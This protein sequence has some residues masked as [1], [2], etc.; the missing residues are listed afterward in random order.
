[1]QS[2]SKSYNI[3]KGRYNMDQYP[4]MWIDIILRK[5]KFHLRYKSMVLKLAT[6]GG[7]PQ[8]RPNMEPRDIQRNNPPVR[9]L[10]TPRN[11]LVVRLVHIPRGEERRGNIPRVMTLKILRKRNHS[12][13]MEKLKRGKNHKFGYLG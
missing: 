4:I 3:Y 5:P 1:M 6:Q 11:F 10:T 9:K 7:A 13:F 8:R 2:Y 12:L